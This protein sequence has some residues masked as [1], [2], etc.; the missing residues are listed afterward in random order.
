[1]VIHSNVDIPTGPLLVIKSALLLL[2]PGVF[3]KFKSGEDERQRP[4]SIVFRRAIPVLNGRG[5]GTHQDEVLRHR[6]RQISQRLR[7]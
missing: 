7:E 3:E 4:C 1:M 5:K 6:A 2:E